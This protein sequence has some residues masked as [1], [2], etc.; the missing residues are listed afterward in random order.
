VSR[1]GALQL[2][3]KCRPVLQGKHT[4]NL[5]KQQAKQPTS[6]K[7]KLPSQ[8]RPQDQELWQALRQLRA[9]LAKQ[10]DVPAYVIFSDAT[11][12]EMCRYRPT[13]NDG[14]RRINGV[15][16]QKRQRYGKQFITVIKQ[17]PLSE[18]LNNQL[19][20]TINKTLSLYE[21][22]MDAEQISSERSLN[23]ST[24]YSH[25]AEAIGAGLLELE[26]VIDLDSSDIHHIIDTID[27]LGDRADSLKNI[28]QALD[29]QYEYHVIRCVVAS[30]F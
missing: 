10:N 23:I 1:Y 28:H 2:T 6:K 29:E 27:E 13:D 21:Q 24:I 14:L 3:E 26:E 17:H 4:L 19:S 25:L 20:E 12:Q 18:L 22:G 16:E 8:I 9:E 7:A 15:G 11:L 5:R 30:V